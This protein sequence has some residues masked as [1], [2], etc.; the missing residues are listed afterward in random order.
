MESSDPVSD[1]A[2]INFLFL[3]DQVVKVVGST[4][5][6]RPFC[7]NAWCKFYE[8]LVTL[9]LVDDLDISTSALHSVHLCEAPGGFVCALNHFVQSGEC[10]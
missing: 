4:I 9:R 2:G 5:K 8:L 7:S 1:H 3:F 6:P 10:G